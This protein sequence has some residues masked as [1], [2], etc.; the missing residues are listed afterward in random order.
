MPWAR[1]E[2]STCTLSSAIGPFLRTTSAIWVSSS[3]SSR[4]W[5]LRIENANLNPSGSP[6]AM[7]ENGKRIIVAASTPPPITISAWTS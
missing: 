3:M 5:E 7:P 2:S 1:N 6:C 4:G